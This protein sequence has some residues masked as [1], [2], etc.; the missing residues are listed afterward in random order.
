MS[1]K[2]FGHE[3][4]KVDIKGTQQT[5]QANS[6]NPIETPAVE[7]EVF[8]QAVSSKVDGVNFSVQ[9]KTLPITDIE[10]Q[11][12]VIK[13]LTE[14]YK[15]LEEE[16]NHSK[17]HKGAIGTVWNGFKNLVGMKTGSKKT[18][19][20]IAEL[21]KDLD[22]LK[23]N[24]EKI[25]EIYKKVTGKELTIVELNNMEKGENPLTSSK[26]AE[27]V[28]KYTES[29]NNARGLVCDMASGIT[30]G[31]VYTAAVAAAPFTGGASIAVGVVAAS[32][33]G[34]LVKTSVNALDKLSAGE[35]YTLSDAKYDMATGALNGVLAPI[36]AG[37]GG[38]V[39]KGIGGV[40]VKEGVEEVG[41]QIAKEATKGMLKE[42]AKEVFAKEGIKGLGKEFVKDFGKEMA[43]NFVVE[44]TEET[45]TQGTKQIFGNFF[46]ESGKKVF[47]STVQN[48]VEGSV[49]G[50]VGNTA[51]YLLM[52]DKDKL[53]LEGAATAFGQGAVGGFIA[54][55]VL[56]G[57]N[58]VAGI[59]FGSVSNKFK[60]TKVVTKVSSK[61]NPSVVS[62][63]ATGA[64]WVALGQL[65]KELP[66]GFK[67][68][69][70]KDSAVQ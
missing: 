40:F 48:A 8:A 37:I 16:Y 3:F 44:G 60:D 43:K 5:G 35:K 26:K 22:D 57:A 62:T 23:K 10:N 41:T 46:K 67:R 49:W 36:T 28:R 38:A 63:V 30:A 39:A 55:G 69:F 53:T 51:D 33:A 64:N 32:A 27:S 34:S 45:V 42:T 20:E 1:F 31:L 7:P 24:P 15:N 19:T 6:S 52:T 29:Q 14:S 17:T 13:N 54:G 4:G 25:A 65:T 61:V 58:E 11:A 68:S 2:L 66:K 59:G 21:K 9:S 47:V 50:S 18:D 56:G 12:K 70:V